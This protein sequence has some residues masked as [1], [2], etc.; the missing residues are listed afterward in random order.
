MIPI[1]GM[2]RRTRDI[3]S[4]T[5]SCFELADLLLLIGIEGR[6][7]ELV[8]E[9]GNN[10]GSLLFH[11]GRILLAFSPYTKAIGDQLVEQGVLKESELLDALQAQRTGPPIP[12][13][14]LLMQ[15]EKVKFE[16]IEK[17][18][19]EQIRAAIKDFSSWKPVEFNF[20]KKEMHPV[21]AIHLTVG[22]F[23][24]NDVKQSA[25]SFFQDLGNAV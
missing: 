15:R 11:Q 17:L 18:V 2:V 12:L 10:I 8:I 6:S 20:I 24:P 14:R 25:R 1:H 7:G 16:V 3:M 19:H 22:E 21:D 13:G 9:S 5:K 4:V 23:L